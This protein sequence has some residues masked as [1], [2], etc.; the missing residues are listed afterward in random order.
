[1]STTADASKG[2]PSLK[3]YR[4]LIKR[5]LSEDLGSEGDV[6][7]AAIF[8][9]ERGSARLT[10]KSAGVVAGLDIFAAVFAEVDPETVVEPKVAD[11]E[12]VEPGDVVAVVLGRAT[13][14]LSGERTALN[15]ISYLSGIATAAKELSSAA[16]GGTVIL[17]TRKT[18]PGYRE[19]AKYAV[20]MGGAKNH[21]MGLFD[22]V[23]IKDNHIDLA[24]SIEAA[25]R[26]VRAK[27]SDR[28]PIEVE[29]RTLR[30]VEEALEARVDWIMLDNMRPREIRRAVKRVG[31]RAKVELSGN[32]SLASVKRLSGPGV[33]Y[34]SVG[35]LTH[36]V[37][38]FDLSLKVEAILS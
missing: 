10:S 1:M 22:M 28:F 30:E 27:W 26:R 7:T 29:C 12:A 15:F 4:D 3:V 2:A 32:M 34:I 38:A 8:A 19:L 33:D 21:R 11:G 24:G 13:S 16:R 9:D 6:T 36:S 20:R 5:A 37:R 25:V 35:G 14:L 18:L 31:G 23:L 17:D